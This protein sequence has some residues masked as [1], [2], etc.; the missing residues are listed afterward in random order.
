MKNSLEMLEWKNEIPEIIQRY[1]VGTINVVRRGLDFAY[2]YVPHSHYDESKL[3]QRWRRPTDT[4]SISMH[5][6]VLNQQ[7]VT[8]CIDHILSLGLES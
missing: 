2:Y 3:N 1:T 8:N 7:S 4:E 5:A 6:S